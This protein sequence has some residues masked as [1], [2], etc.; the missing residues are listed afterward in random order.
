[1][2]G[3][4]DDGQLTL[5]HAKILAGV[6]AARQVGFARL[7]ARRKLSVRAL[8]T[9]WRK[10]QNR[11]EQQVAGD[12]AASREMAA[13]E[14]RLSEHLGNQVRIRFDPERRDGEIRVGFHDLDEFEGL[15]ARWGFDAQG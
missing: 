2:Q 15:L 13:L 12:T 10:D 1:M 8:E 6:P 4:I 14:Q 11:N 9:H 3:L 5:G 7:A